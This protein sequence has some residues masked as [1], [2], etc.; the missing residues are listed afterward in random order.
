MTDFSGMSKELSRKLNSL[1]KV[2]LMKKESFLN[3]IETCDNKFKTILQDSIEKL[4]EEKL[5]M[6]STLEQEREMIIQT[7]SKKI[8]QAYTDQI[9]ASTR[10]R[11]V[12]DLESGKESEEVV[13]SSFGSD[14]EN[15]RGELT[16]E[17]RR[18]IKM[19][20]IELECVKQQ[21]KMTKREAKK[22]IPHI[23]KTIYEKMVQQQINLMKKPPGLAM[24]EGEKEQ[25]TDK[26]DMS[27]ESS[28]SRSVG[29]FEESSQHKH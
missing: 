11:S 7:M 6:E 26:S 22:R 4:F 29:Y 9:E 23:E 5:I 25:D 14:S 1:Q 27:F 2:R 17:D 8:A 19:L 12:S 15:S 16:I 24:S 10:S 3:S 21:M 28:S 18:K 20:E 13:N